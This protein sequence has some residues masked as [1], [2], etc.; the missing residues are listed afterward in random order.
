LA[1][2]WTSYRAHDV[3]LASVGSTGLTKST[4]RQYLCVSLI[5][6]LDIFRCQNVNN[7]PSGV[8]LHID[9]YDLHAIRFFDEN[10]VESLF[11]S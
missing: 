10:E 11:Y 6:Y 4:C 2:P 9:S 1:F 8:F 3:L 7:L 5:M